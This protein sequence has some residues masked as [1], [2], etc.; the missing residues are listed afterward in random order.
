[1]MGPF[2]HMMRM[3]ERRAEKYAQGLCVY[4]SRPNDRLPLKSCGVCYARLKKSN[5]K[6]RRLYN[7][8]RDQ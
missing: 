6:Y 4:C 7:V 3:R 2:G 8:N 5:K 1:M